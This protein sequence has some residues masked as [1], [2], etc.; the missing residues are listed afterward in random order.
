MAAAELVEVTG[1]AVELAE[2]VVAFRDLS[3]ALDEM[4]QPHLD[5]SRRVVQSFL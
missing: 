3:R 4:D 2:L 5:C 1:I